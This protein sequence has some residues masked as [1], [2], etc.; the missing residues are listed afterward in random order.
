MVTEISVVPTVTERQ[1]RDAEVAAALS[2][3]FENV[4]VVAEQVEEDEEDDDDEENNV[5]DGAS[6]KKKKKRKNKKK[7]TK[8]KDADQTVYDDSL[9]CS[10]VLG[11]KRD[12]F[13][14]FGQT[15][16]PTIP[17]AELKFPGDKYPEGEI[18]THGKTKIPNPHSAW[19]RTTEEEK[20]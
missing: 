16:P 3:A 9:T 11:G 17:V 5:L 14:K 7:S 12:Y 15:F 8:K 6:N 4:K 18:Q 2:S 10:R 20:R 19:S 13:L 1:G